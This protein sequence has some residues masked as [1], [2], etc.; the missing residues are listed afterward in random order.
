MNDFSE[1]TFS[2][3]IDHFTEDTKD[4]ASFNQRYW[5]ND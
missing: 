4:T 2:N 5:M 3:R 1:L